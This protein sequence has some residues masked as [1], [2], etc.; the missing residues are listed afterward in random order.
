MT[1]LG[2]SE[3]E[4][5]SRH[6]RKDTRV[7]PIARMAGKSYIWKFRPAETK[8]AVTRF[9]LEPCEHY[10]QWRLGLKW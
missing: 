7:V 4:A 1:G 9:D 3:T 5:D 6:G 10:L 8:G 2:Q